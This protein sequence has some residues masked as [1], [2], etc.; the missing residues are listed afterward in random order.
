MAC[1][2]IV[3]KAADQARVRAARRSG[4]RVAPFLHL[5]VPASRPTLPTCTPTPIRLPARAL[6]EVERG[7]DRGQVR[8]GRA[9][10]RDGW[11]SAPPVRHR[12]NRRLRSHDPRSGRE[13][14]RPAGRHPRTVHGR[15]RTPAGPRDRA[16]R[17]ALVRRA[18]PARRRRRDG[19]GRRPEHGADRHRRAADDQVRVRPRVGGSGGLDRPAQPRSCRRS[20][21]G[22]E[23]RRRWPRRS[24]PRSLRTATTARSGSPPTCSW[25]RVRRTS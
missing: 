14:R 25:R 7:F 18:R 16:V 21:R 12:A 8:P 24:V 2:D 22:Q 20:A 17:P 13:S 4:T 19:A 23:D 11:P 5:P 9:V 15:R 1:W 10:H 6:E 3:G